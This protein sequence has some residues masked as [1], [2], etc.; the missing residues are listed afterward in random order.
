MANDNRKN[1]WIRVAGLA[2]LVVALVYVG[3]RYVAPLTRLVSNTERFNDYIQSF[4]A[5]GVLVF[6]GMQ[7]LQVV[8]APIPGELTQLAGGFIYGTVWGTV[9][10]VAG[11]LVGSVIVFFAG[12]LF[13]FPLV[14]ALI[15]ADKLQKFDFLINNPKAE[16]FMLLLFLIPG[17]PKDILTYIAGV[18]PVRSLHFILPAMVARL[19]GILLSSYIGAHVE[20]QR[21]MEVIIASAIAVGLFLVGVL[22]QD[23]LTRSL[24]RRHES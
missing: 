13:G 7:V 2:L 17:S 18:T 6:M 11:I 16:L 3:I 4:G 20:E 10:S 15:P 14:K 8:V 12:R 5:W 22:F 1:L 9:Y 24:K 23:R 19:P 21:Y